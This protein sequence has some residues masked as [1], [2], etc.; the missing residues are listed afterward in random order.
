MAIREGAWDCPHCGQERNRGPHKHCPSCGFAR[1]PEVPFY[2]PPDAAVVTDATALAAAHAG[3]DWSCQYCET[4]NPSGHEFCSSCG[5]SK[6]GAPPRPVIEYLD[7]PEAEPVKQEEKKKPGCIKR[8]CTWILGGGLA[9]FILALIFGGPTEDTITV[10]GHRWERTIQI[11]A[12]ITETEQAWEGSVPSDARVISSERAIQRVNKVQIGT[13]TKTRT[14]NKKVQVGTEKVKVGVRDLGNGYFEDI[15]EE[16]PVYE[17]KQ[18]TETYQDPVYREDP[19]YRQRYTYEVDRWKTVR[20]EVA[21][22][23]DMNPVWPKVNLRGRKERQGRK[24]QIYEV[25]FRGSEGKLFIMKTKSEQDWHRYDI[26]M[27][28]KA[29]VQGKEVKNILGPA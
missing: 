4:D 8:G 20:P 21:T 13:E 7:K 27:R 3:P 19:V 28:Y 12:L 25:H 11:E 17:T 15:Y 9:T 24:D 6:D 18:F 5:A 26:G 2:L 14:V 1:G 23:R 22:G 16:R 29:K 10:E